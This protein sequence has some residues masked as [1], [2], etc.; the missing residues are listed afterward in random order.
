M[1]KVK[2]IYATKKGEPQYLEDIMAELNIKEDE[3]KYIEILKNNNYE[4][5]RVSIVDLN[6]EAN[7]I[8][9]INI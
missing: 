9:S 1:Q 6:T 2:L 8:K 3:S 7:F 5:I 4:N